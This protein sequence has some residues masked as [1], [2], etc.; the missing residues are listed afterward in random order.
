[1]LFKCSA[2]VKTFIEVNVECNRGILCQFFRGGTSG[3]P[4]LLGLLSA[5]ENTFARL[6]KKVQKAATVVLPL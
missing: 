2:S 5:I 6:E 3:H 4:G 1:M